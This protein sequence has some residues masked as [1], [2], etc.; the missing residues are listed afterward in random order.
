MKKAM[1]H[2]IET[3]FVRAFLG[4]RLWVSSSVGT[5]VIRGWGCKDIWARIITMVEDHMSYSQYFP[6]SLMDMGSL[7]GAILGTILN[8]KRDPYIHC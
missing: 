2:G 7:L 6:D 1:E 8:Y 4:V 5:V 3:G